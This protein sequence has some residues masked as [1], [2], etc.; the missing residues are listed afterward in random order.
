MRKDVETINSLKLHGRQLFSAGRRNGR[1]FDI[2]THS[3]QYVDFKSGF[4]LSAHNLFFADR[5]RWRM[6]GGKKGAAV[7]MS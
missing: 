3:A 7:K 1:F 6:K 2:N 4:I 5:R